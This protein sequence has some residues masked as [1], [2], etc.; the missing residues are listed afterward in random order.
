MWDC[1]CSEALCSLHAAHSY[2]SSSGS[3]LGFSASYIIFL[4]VKL[5]YQPV[6]HLFSIVSSPGLPVGVLGSC[7]IIS[8]GSTGWMLSPLLFAPFPWLLT[9]QISGWCLVNSLTSPWRSGLSCGF[10]VCLSKMLQHEQMWAG[11]RAPSL[12]AWPRKPAPVTFRVWPT[13]SPQPRRR[14]AASGQT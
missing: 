5:P 9:L 13:A 12:S 10:K 1:G 11:R 2:S 6:S 7:G 3:H 8:L 4:H 14:P